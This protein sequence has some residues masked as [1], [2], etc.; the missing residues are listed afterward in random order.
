M[1]NR[2]AVMPLA[3][4]LAA[5]GA[6]SWTNAHT[7]WVPLNRVVGTVART[8]DFDRQMRPMH[9]Y[10]RHRWERV[11]AARSL[12]MT[13]PPV[14]LVQL[15][16]LYFVDDGH[17]RVSVA[18]AHG[19]VDIEARVR[20]VCTV[21]YACQC[22]TVTDLESKAAER[23]FLERVPLPD[24]VRPWLWLDDPAD[25]QR[26]EPAALDWILGDEA[27]AGAAP[28]SRNESQPD[29]GRRWCR[30]RGDAADVTPTS[31]TTCAPSRAGTTTA[32]A[33]PDGCGSWVNST[34]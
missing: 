4:S 16:E 21:A 3:R 30:A 17:H 27:D 24:D 10:L 34:C 26:L 19:A 6:D 25:W 32:A 28:P 31:R 12:A 29:D 5:L 11:A 9:R 18:R 1:A 15:G 23:E 22:L 2:N 14:R 20:R 8:D 13:L 7:D 33:A